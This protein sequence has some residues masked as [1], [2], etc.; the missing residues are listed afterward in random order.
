MR[1]EPHAIGRLAAR[2]PHGSAVIS[3][4]NGKTTTAAMVAAILERGGTRLV[5]NRAGAN[6]AGGVA[7]ALLQAA[8][9]GARLSGDTGLF[10]V[11][12]FWLGAGRRRAA[13]ARPAARATSSATSSTA[14]ASSTRSP[15]AGST[16]APARAPT[17]VLNADDPTVADLGRAR[18]GDAA[19]AACLLRRR[20]RRDRAG[21]DAARRRRQ[22]LPPL[23]RAV[24][25][26]RDLPRP[27]RPLP[28][29]QLRRAPRPSRRSR[30][31]DVVLE[32]VRGARFT[33][34]TPA[35]ERGVALPLP[36]LYN[37]Y[38]ALGAAALA[39][40]LGAPLD[41]VAAGLQA[42]SPAFGR[43]ET[44]RL[45]GPRD[46]DPA[47]QEP[48]RGERGAAHARARAGRARPARD[49]QRPRRRRARRELGLGRRLRGARRPRAPR[50]V[51]RHARGGDGAA[52]EVRGR[53]DRADR[54]RDRRSTRAS[55]ARSRDGDGRLF[56][57]PTYTAMLGLRDVLVAR[58]AAGSSFA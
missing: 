47:R 1:L 8:R 27:P 21:R 50:D 49:P 58:G 4:T 36:G 35:G 26:R 38:N 22:A 5:H 40:T 29:R 2:L 3:A 25:L 13:A 9:R 30:P 6:M 14:T 41:D 56:A 37:V 46:V 48:G 44:V 42:V 24:P 53:A 7:S 20:G 39:L 33:L 51:Q 31:P 12:E 55:T 34:R 23:R 16:C 18:G 28:L 11:D 32:G 43:A 15:T 52:A 10:E 57:L 17:L 19:A 54:G 45:G